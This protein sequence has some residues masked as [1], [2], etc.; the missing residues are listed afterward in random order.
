M[1]SIRLHNDVMEQVQEAETRSSAPWVEIAPP[2]AGFDESAPFASARIPWQKRAL[3]LS[4]IF[5]SMPVWFPMMVLISMWIVLVSRGP[6]FF[7]QERIGFHGRKFCLLKF[8]S[9]KVNA[10][11]STHE[12][13]VRDL[14]HSEKPMT[15]L[16]AAGDPRLIRFGRL[17]RA[18]GLDEL[19]QLF[20]VIRGDMSLVGPRP[21]TPAE[22]QAY[23]PWQKERVTALPGLT[24]SWQVNGKNKTTFSEMVTMD[25]AYC[26]N[27]SVKRDLEIM[28]RTIPTIVS[29]ILETRAPAAQSQERGLCDAA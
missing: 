10:D 21:C 7:R 22:F 12:G 20:N 17:F 2:D 25:I 1:I 13:H 18:S 9:M 26:R 19:P 3:D 16:D 8:R 11:T 14:I 27:V 24:G 6:V 4:L 23:A 29:L 28:G 15:K 5:I